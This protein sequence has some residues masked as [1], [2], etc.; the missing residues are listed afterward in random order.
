[1]PQ[2]PDVVQAVYDSARSAV[3]GRLQPQSYDRRILSINVVGPLG[4][5]F[6]LY[7]GYELVDANLISTTS[8]GSRNQYDSLTGGAPV[9]IRA[10]EAATFAWTGASAT[11]G[12]TATATVISQWGE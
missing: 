1:M 11:V 8:K 12:A 9:I 2:T 7:R 4:S 6:S 10:G 5:T 3:V